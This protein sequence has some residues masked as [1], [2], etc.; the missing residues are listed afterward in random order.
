MALLKENHVFFGSA[1][2]LVRGNGAN[3]ADTIKI[4]AN[5]L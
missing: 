5:R 1:P 2:V 4:F 3:I